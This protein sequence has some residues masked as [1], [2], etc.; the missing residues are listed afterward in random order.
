MPGAPVIDTPRLTLR[1]A[2]A[3]DAE[4][5]CRLMNEPGWRQN[6][7]DHDVRSPADAAAYLEHRY[8]PAY[9]S[10]LGA[11]VVRVTATDVPIGICGLFQRP[12]MRCPDLGFAL[13]SSCQGEGYAFEAASAVLGHARQQTAAERLAAI[14]LP[15]NG[16]SIHLLE[17]LGFRCVGHVQAGSD[18]EVLSVYDLEW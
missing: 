13:L 1:E 4:F 15:G 10:G 11:R 8:V 5:L 14:T 18:S 6:I 2:T 12:W 17:K 9:A 7:G 3:A 16:P